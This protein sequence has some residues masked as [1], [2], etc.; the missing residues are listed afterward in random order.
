MASC[1]T[2]LFIKHDDTPLYQ[3]SMELIY[4]FKV[5]PSHY[6]CAKVFFCQ[7]TIGIFDEYDDLLCRLR[8]CRTNCFNSALI[9]G[10]Q[11]SIHDKRVRL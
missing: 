9:E 6:F 1:K 4:F 3:M 2:I 8:N 11:R 10:R 5:M 7:L